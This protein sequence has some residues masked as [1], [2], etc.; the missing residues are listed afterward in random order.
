LY[1][2]YPL[3]LPTHL[4]SQGSQQVQ[5]LIY[6][7]LVTHLTAIQ[8]QQQQL[9]LLSIINTTLLISPHLLPPFFFPFFI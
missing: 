9:T 6:L 4:P 1:N 5:Q 8:Q 7:G 3:C 2:T